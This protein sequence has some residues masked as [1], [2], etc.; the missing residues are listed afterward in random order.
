MAQIEEVNT[1]LTT[2]MT[3]DKLLQSAPYEFRTA[4][5]G[6]SVMQ[7]DPCGSNIHPDT[8]L[9]FHEQSISSLDDTGSAST[10][11]G[12]IGGGAAAGNG[13]A[14]V[15]DANGGASD[16]NAGNGHGND[17]AGE[18]PGSPNPPPSDD[19]HPGG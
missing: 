4:V 13:H 5:P 17:G 1:G 12:R 2:A 14:V 18:H 8:L 10:R 7:P 16:G 15:G 11:F 6:S 9:P 19:G 3:G